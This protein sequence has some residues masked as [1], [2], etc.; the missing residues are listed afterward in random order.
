MDPGPR[1][2]QMPEQVPGWLG[3]LDDPWGIT[4]RVANLVKRFSAEKAA[5][6][7]LGLVRGVEYSRPV[8]VI[9]VPRSGTTML[10]QLLKASDDLAGLTREAH[11]LW[12]LF[13]HP[14]YGGW[15]SDVVGPNEVRFGEKR[16]VDA[17]F[18]AHFGARRFVEKTPENALRIPYIL[19]LYPDA[20]FLV[21]KRD[22]CDVVNSLVN[23]WRH[24]KGRY[25]AYYVPT[26]LSIPGYDHPRRWCFSLVEGWRD[27]TSSPIPEIVLHQWRS[28]TEAI[29]SGREIVPR[30]QWTEVHF[31]HLLATPDDT[32]DR[33]CERVGIAR[34]Q[35]LRA[36]LAGL[37]AEPVNAL[38]APRA[39]KWRF[40]NRAEIESLL[41]RLAETA[42]LAGYRVDPLTGEFEIHPCEPSS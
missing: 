38:S 19:D 39:N 1:I 4:W 13:H 21:I 35:A 32:L 11:D 10:F 42:R 2:K 15:R 18:Y 31:E 40:E 5:K 29:A 3:R 12:R 36:R 22:P 14:R 9:G 20:H 17:Y 41:P 7:S 28:V 37:L 33:I 8:F 30:A 16:L 24:P 34:T 27:F 23:G 26:N 6:L 25:R